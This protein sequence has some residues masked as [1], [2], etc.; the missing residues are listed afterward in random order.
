MSYERGAPFPRWYE[1]MPR[2]PLPCRVFACEIP[3][4]T[5]DYE[6]LRTPVRMI[7]D[8]LD[9]QIVWA[10]SRL[11]P[12]LVQHMAC[13][14]V[15]EILERDPTNV[16][17]L[18]V[19]KDSY[20]NQ[21]KWSFVQAIAVPVP[22]PTPMRPVETVAAVAVRK[23]TDLSVAPSLFDCVICSETMTE[24]CTISCGHSYC[25]ACIQ[26][27]IET[28]SETCPCCRAAILE[29]PASLTVSVCLQTTIMAIRKI[30]S[31]T[32]ATAADAT[33]ACATDVADHVACLPADP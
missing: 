25:R 1:S 19:G 14:K 15:I 7:C 10:K 5:A 16:F 33:A 29:T 12:G 3:Y 26:R 28:G 27:W 21:E 9:D 11:N 30:T 8:I 4:V 18:R 24:P 23:S 17:Q 32:G 6:V 31:R 20:I 13:V 22:A 2:P